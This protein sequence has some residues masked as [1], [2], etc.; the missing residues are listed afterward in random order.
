MDNK[1]IGYILLIIGIAIILFSG[2]SVYQ[3]FNG[4][5]MPYELFILNSINI[6]LKTM[7]T[8]EQASLITGDSNIEIFSG[9]V[10]TKF[11][12]IFM[13]LLLMG[14][15]GS[16]GYK[17]SMIGSHMIKTIEFKIKNSKENIDFKEKIVN[18]K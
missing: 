18:T 8:P 5:T 14:F 17:V 15:L 9:E 12:N 1:I 3:V 16:I 2:F 6:D 13:H 11:T 7:L 4:Q 10:F